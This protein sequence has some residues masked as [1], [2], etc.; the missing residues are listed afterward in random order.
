MD[1]LL[2]RTFLPL[3]NDK[4]HYEILNEYASSRISILLEQLSTEKDMDRV[5]SIQ[6]AIGELRRIKTLRDEVVAGSK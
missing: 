4:E 6:G 2:F 3:V 1:K 5:K